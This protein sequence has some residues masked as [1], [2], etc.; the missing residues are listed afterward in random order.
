MKTKSL[1]LVHV[2][3]LEYQWG[4]QDGKRVPW[5]GLGEGG[6]GSHSQRATGYA[7]QGKFRIN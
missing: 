7:E 5:S 4:A 6:G 2:A 1:F 3:V